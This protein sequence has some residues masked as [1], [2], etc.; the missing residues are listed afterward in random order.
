MHAGDCDREIPA[1]YFDS[2]EGKCK[3]FDFTGC[4]GSDNRFA[5]EYE[6]YESCGVRKY[7]CKANKIIPVFLMTFEKKQ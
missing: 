6:C 2:E 4:G 1:W 7:Y 3:E 5:S